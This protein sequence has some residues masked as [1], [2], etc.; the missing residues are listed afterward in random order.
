MRMQIHETFSHRGDRPILHNHCINA[1]LYA[2]NNNENWIFDLAIRQREMMG[3][4]TAHV[5]IA[6]FVYLLQTL[7]H[8]LRPKIGKYYVKRFAPLVWV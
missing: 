7:K 3:K 8:S 5:A 1:N 4:L 6:F 2:T